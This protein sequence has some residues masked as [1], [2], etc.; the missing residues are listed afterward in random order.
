LLG[1]SDK[2]SIL[3]GG[4]AG[5]VIALFWQKH[6]KKTKK[7]SQE[8]ID[9][10]K[11]RSYAV[12]AQQNA[13]LPESQAEQTLLPLAKKSGAYSGIINRPFQRG[14]LIDDLKTNHY[15][16]GRILL[17][18]KADFNLYGDARWEAEL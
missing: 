5:T 15:P 13:L 14:D 9:I 11:Q 12:K 4:I 6:T 2:N 18:A 10:Q 17:A 7:K 16:T 8:Y 1:V 3:I